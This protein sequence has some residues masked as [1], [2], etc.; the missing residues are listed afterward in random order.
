MRF[1]LVVAVLLAV[2]LGAY[3]TSIPVG[4]C[5]TG[6]SLAYY[7][8]TYTLLGQGCSVG[9]WT[10]TNFNYELVSFPSPANQAP[11]TLK[12][13]AADIMLT[14]PA[15][16]TEAFGFSSSNFAV[17]YN[18]AK[19]VGN[20]AIYKVSYTIDPFP[21]IIPGFDVEMD[22][23]TPKGGGK[24]T[25]TTDICVHQD[26][27]GCYETKTF[28]VVYDSGVNGEIKLKNSVLFTPTNWIDVSHT[29]KLEALIPGSS[30]Q[31][32]GLKS[33]VVGVVP[34]PG[35]I[36]LGAIGLGLLALLRLRR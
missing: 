33:E 16:V 34:E 3:G 25:I 18:D 5:P 9:D 26:A 31:I 1:V 32:S 21:P 17:F 28:D 22:T 27:P 12:A 13:L 24:A 20:T 35:T 7:V 19:G 36:A 4:A 8:N 29:I 2:A 15:V 10:Y 14:P 11:G 23:F 30:S 6:Q